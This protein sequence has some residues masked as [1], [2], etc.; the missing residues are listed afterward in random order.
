MKKKLYIISTIS[1]IIFLVFSLLI[2]RDYRKSTDIS[3][4]PV[5]KVDKKYST[6]KTWLVSYASDG[7][8]IQ[9]QNNLN[10]SASMTG[11]FDGVISYQAHHIDTEYYEKHE[12]ILSQKRGVGYW[13][14]KPY[15]IL[16]ALKMIPEND[17]LFYADLS[18]I[19]RDEVHKVLELAKHHDIIL[20][21]NSNTNRKYMKKAVIDKMLNGNE[22]FRDKKQLE[23]GFLLLRNNPKTRAFIE[24]WLNH[25][26]DEDLLTDIPSKGGEYPDFLDHRHDQAVLTAL[27]YQN[28]EQYHLYDPYPAR[29][30]A[31][32]VTRRHNPDVSLASVTFNK[33]LGNFKWP[34]WSKFYVKWLIDDKNLIS[35]CN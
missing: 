13:L 3:L 25:C 1:L 26:E 19:F 7:V 34:S 14:W 23:G 10:M 29:V 15:I 21:P 2:L 12:K 24:K 35:R 4:Y 33:E 22:N 5:K 27:Y 17:V 31:F 18:A 32:C 16:K 28:P 20:F 30:N 8:Y 9:N 11:A 6:E